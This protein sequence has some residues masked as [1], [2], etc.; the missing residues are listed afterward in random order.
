MSAESPLHPIQSE[1]VQHVLGMDGDAVHP[2]LWASVAK[3]DK[4]CTVHFHRVGEPRVW[5]VVVKRAE[6]TVTVEDIAL[7]RAI[8]AAVLA[9]EE[10]GWP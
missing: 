4:C 3:L 5:R 2:D 10:R 7:A 6:E 1:K 9:A 8:T